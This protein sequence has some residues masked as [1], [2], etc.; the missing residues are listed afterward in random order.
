[1]RMKRVGLTRRI[2]E[3]AKANVTEK[4][5]TRKGGGRNGKQG[6][7]KQSL[8]KIYQ[9]TRFYNQGEKRHSL[10]KKKKRAGRPR[11][12][13]TNN[14]ESPLKRGWGGRFVAKPKEK[15]EQ[16]EAADWAQKKKKGEN[17]RNQ[18]QGKKNRR[19]Q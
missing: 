8:S 13:R 5:I 1:M 18:N 2:K 19:T 15:K 14:T 7:G 16:K 6:G 11:R 4:E 17:T 3:A 12:E 10:V 9:T